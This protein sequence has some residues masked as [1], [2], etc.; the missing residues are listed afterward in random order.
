MLLSLSAAAKIAG[1]TRQ[2]MRYAC[3]DGRLAYTP[4]D[5]GDGSK[6]YLLKKEDVIAFRDAR[7]S[8]LIDER[9]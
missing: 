2:S 5:R 3:L 7:Q 9:R 1:V 6:G 8:R 4:F